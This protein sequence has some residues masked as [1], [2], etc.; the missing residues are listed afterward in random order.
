MLWQSSLLIALLFALE[1]LLRRKVRPAGTIRLVAGRAREALA[2]ALA[3]LPHQR[4]LVV[5]SGNRRPA[6]APA[7]PG[8]GDLWH[9]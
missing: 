9:P 1:L 6:K 8:R 2:P 5:A 7:N 3:R 4:L